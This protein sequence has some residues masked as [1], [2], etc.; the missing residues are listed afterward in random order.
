MYIMGVFIL[1]I[2]QENEDDELVNID[3][4]FSNF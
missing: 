3:N 1:T 4:S 2:V